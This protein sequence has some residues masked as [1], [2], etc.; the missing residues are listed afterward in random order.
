MGGD[1]VSAEGGV[2][3]ADV[4]CARGGAAGGRGK[5]GGLQRYPTP[6][7]DEENA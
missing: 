7:A 5:T 6:E 4:G 3:D 1:G 2:A